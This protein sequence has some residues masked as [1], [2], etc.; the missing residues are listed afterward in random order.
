MLAFFGSIVC[1][2]W[3]KVTAEFFYFIKVNEF[4]R[5]FAG[6]DFLTS[7]EKLVVTTN[8]NRTTY[9]RICWPVLLL[10]WAALASVA[11]FDLVLQ[12]RRLRLNREA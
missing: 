6:L 7:A 1:P 12:I 8:A 4:E 3:E 10:E 5:G 11:G 2:P 9:Y